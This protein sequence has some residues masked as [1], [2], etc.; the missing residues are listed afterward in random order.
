MALIHFDVEAVS[1][2]LVIED[3][4]FENYVNGVGGAWTLTI[5]L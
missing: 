1:T 4:N 2:Y 3:G 5:L